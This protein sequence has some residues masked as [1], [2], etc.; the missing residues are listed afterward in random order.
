MSAALAFLAGVIL[1]LSIAITTAPAVVPHTTDK[2]ADC[3]AF[4]N[5]D[6]IATEIC[7]PLLP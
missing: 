5:G 2:Y 6:D 7:E 3:I 4:V 1:A